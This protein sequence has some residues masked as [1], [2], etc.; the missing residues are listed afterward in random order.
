MQK[1]N[2]NFYGKNKFTGPRPKKQTGLNYWRMENELLRKQSKKIFFNL[3]H[4]LAMSSRKMSN[5]DLKVL[6]QEE[7]ASKQSDRNFL[8]M[9]SFAWN[10][11]E[12]DGKRS[13]PDGL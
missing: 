9:N 10:Q 4:F 11:F 1:K 12:F 3:F 2:I 13:R 6:L 7:Q 8:R 5:V